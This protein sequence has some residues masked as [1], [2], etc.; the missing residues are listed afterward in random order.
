MQ[1]F[2]QETFTYISSTGLKYEATR[3]EFIFGCPKDTFDNTNNCLSLLIKKLR[4]ALQGR[5]V[6]IS[7]KH[8]ISHIF[9]FIDSY[10]N[11]CTGML[12]LICSRIEESVIIQYLLHLKGTQL[13]YKQLF[14]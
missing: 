14:V 8:F 1:E 7:K 9:I 11:M 13:H 10:N 5:R 12:P 2:I 6:T 4:D 3:N